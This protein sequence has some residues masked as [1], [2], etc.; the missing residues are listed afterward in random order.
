M[1]EDEFLLLSALVGHI[2]PRLARLG[3]SFSQ[4]QMLVYYIKKEAVVVI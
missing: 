2:L 4:Q 3:S 1:T